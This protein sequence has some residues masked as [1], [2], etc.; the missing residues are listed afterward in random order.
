MGLFS[1]LSTTTGSKQPSKAPSSSSSSALSIPTVVQLYSGDR[2]ILLDDASNVSGFT[3]LTYQAVQVGAVDYSPDAN[4]NNKPAF[5]RH[6]NP[7]L[8]VWN[9]RVHNKRNG[10]MS[11][12][13][14]E[15]ATASA[16]FPPLVDS[17]L[18][19]VASKATTYAW[20]VPLA[21]E[22]SVEPTVSLLKAA[23][24]RHLMDHPPPPVSSSSIGGDDTPLDG[25]EAATM[26]TTSGSKLGL[27]TR[28]TTLYDL[29][30][31]PFGLAP[32]DKATENTIDEATKDCL[33]SLMICAV[34]PNGSSPSTG[35]G[36]DVSGLDGETAYKQKQARAL[37]V[38]HLRKFAYTINASLCFVEEPPAD[39]TPDIVP[40]LSALSPTKEA[41]TTAVVELS[42]SGSNMADD[43]QPTISYDKL[44]QLWRDL[45][46]G[47]P[48]WQFEMSSTKAGT[49]DGGATVVEDDDAATALYGPGR[50]QEDLIESVLLR[51]ANY[52]GHWEASK[53]SLWVALP[54]P[55]EPLPTQASAST[56]GD[57]GWLNQLRDSIASAMPAVTLSGATAADGSGGEGDKQGSK[58]PKEKDAAVS[59]F[60]E[61]LLKNP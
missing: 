1:V 10:S 28:T 45:A 60:F 23:L 25:D 31:T 42:T 20:T 3:A 54:T 39:P 15:D 48:I 34:V 56:T 21:D 16:T 49:V 27:A 41:L 26:N 33:I 2:P 8:G 51:N 22:T 36:G 18:A 6:Y 53:D 44:S 43:A 55:P 47:I 11:L 29:Q 32:D 58:T 57:H 14:P 50:H 52:P 5:S 46:I 35:V 12:A 4:S 17:L 30:A 7:D 9:C 24:V 59:S 61:S 37:V 38:Y 13:G 19:K 40:S